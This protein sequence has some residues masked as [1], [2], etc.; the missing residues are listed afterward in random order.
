[1]PRERSNCRDLYAYLSTSGCGSH[2]A[3]THY[4]SDMCPVSVAAWGTQRK[5]ERERERQTETQT[6][7]ERETDAETQR[8]RQRRRRR[9]RRSERAVPFQAHS[10]PRLVGRCWRIG[11]HR[12][13]PQPAS[14]DSP[15]A[16]LL[17]KEIGRAVATMRRAPMSLA[18]SLCFQERTV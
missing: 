3:S 2:W 16:E 7:K 8:Q 6:E 13:V 17:R 12:A 18:N 9:R 4:T 15:D 11:R 14:P 5:R 10:C 1:M